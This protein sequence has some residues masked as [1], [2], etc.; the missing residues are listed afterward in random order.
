[1]DY[2]NIL[3]VSRGASPSEI[4]AA[5]KKLALRYHP[6][7]NPDDPEAEEKFKQINAAYQVLSGKQPPPRYRR[8]EPRENQSERRYERSYTERERR[9][10]QYRRRQNSAPPPP[11]ED[12]TKNLRYTVYAILIVVCLALISWIAGLWLNEYGAREN[13]KKAR[14]FWEMDDA[15]QA[16]EYL[17]YALEQNELHPAA[18]AL[19]AEMLLENA[20]HSPNPEDLSAAD[21]FIQ[22]AFEH[23]DS[24]PTDWYRLR[25]SIHR[26]NGQAQAALEDWQ[27]LRDQDPAAAPESWV[28]QGDILLHDLSHDRRALRHYQSGLRALGKLLK[29][30]EQDDR[31]ELLVSAQ[32]AYLGQ[33]LAFIR[34]EQFDSTRI[35][36]D[37]A[38]QILPDE[39]RIDYL[40]GFYWLNTQGDTTRACK[41][42]QEALV[43]G[44]GESM[45]PIKAHCWRR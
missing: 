7:R 33:A 24:T 26:R 23:A 29:Q 30:P 28:K 9:R 25:A 22:R 12:E 8:Q 17:N 36:L 40:E 11:Q 38:R 1:M 32:Q 41:Y 31:K 18:N 45:S 43:E 27:Q 13:Y 16:E 35:A 44:I 3:G 10:Q 5:Y 15:E 39:P 34:L 6:D 2:Y 42:W 37:R 21:F 20:E 4:R 19:R 14:L